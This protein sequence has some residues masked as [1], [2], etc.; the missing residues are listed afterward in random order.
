MKSYY[1]Q[2]V[3]PLFMARQNEKKIVWRN[4]LPQTRRI[5]NTFNIVFISDFKHKL[6]DNLSTVDLKG[7][8]AF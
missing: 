3:G 2:L 4:S 5:Y 7:F 6:W 1:K 8:E